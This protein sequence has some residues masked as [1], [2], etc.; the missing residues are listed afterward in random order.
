MELGAPLAD[1]LARRDFTVNTL[2]LRLADGALQGVPEARADLDARVLRVLHDDSFR[3]DPTRLVRLARYAGRLGFEAEPHTAGLARAAVAGGALATVSGERLGAELRLL[4]ARE[5]Q[6]AVLVTLAGYGL[7]DSLLPGF[8][9]DLALAERALALCPADA[10][11]GL[12][13]LGSALR[14][15][16]RP[17]LEARLRAL[18]LPAGELASIVACA[19][20]DELLAGLR[21]A[22]PS[23]ADELLSRR[24]LEAAVLAAAAGSEPARDW[25]GRARRLRVAIG[26]EDLLAAGLSGPAVGRGLRAAR[27]ALLDGEASDAAAQ[28]AAALAAA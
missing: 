10:G 23:R 17:E 8:S 13:A 12:V 28:L 4:L 6:P 16:P 15:A 5:P 14:G 21:G 27:A 26:G 7:G 11:P 20:V 22:R 2:A 1:D 25:I 9:V 18:G 19:G 3:D 24:P